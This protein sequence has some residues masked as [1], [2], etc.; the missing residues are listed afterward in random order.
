MNKSKSKLSS[1][2]MIVMALAIPVTT[3]ILKSE[4]L[5]FRFSAS[6]S[7]IPEHIVM[8][9]VNDTSVIISWITGKEAVGGVKFIESG[10]VF[11]EPEAVRYHTV[12][13]D[14]L[15]KSTSY[16]FAVVSDGIE[17]LNDTSYYVLET[18]AKS[19]LAN[20][21]YYVYGQ[22][23]GLDGLTFQQYGLIYLEL[24]K[25]GIRSQKLVTQINESG[26]YKFN[27]NSLKDE[28]GS[29]RFNYNGQSN[30]T[31]TVQIY[32]QAPIVRKYTVNLDYAKQLPNIYLGD[33]DVEFMPGVE[34]L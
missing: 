21:N 2:A 12:K 4:N 14:S 18:G 26:G 16:K 23:F 15:Q 27:L 9:D 20:S 11:Y 6:D 31:L 22:A 5:D 29:K 1:F 32:G 19:V 25:E 30:V 24:D 10:E 8:S 7:T 17:Y 34:G 13:V 33:V 28:S 3:F